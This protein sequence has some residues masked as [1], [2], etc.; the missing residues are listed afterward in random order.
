VNFIHIQAGIIL[1]LSNRF[2]YLQKNNSTLDI[3]IARKNKET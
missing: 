2:I 3:K 1:I